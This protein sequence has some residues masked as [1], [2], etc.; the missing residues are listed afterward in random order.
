MNPL[1][2]LR[3]IGDL[4]IDWRIMMKMKE[5]TGLGIAIVVFLAN[6]A[7]LFTPFIPKEYQPIAAAG[8]ALL[9]AI[10]V[11]IGYRNNPDGTDIRVGYQGK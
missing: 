5:R 4:T 9:A 7:N 1:K 10:L 3:L 6:A 2:K 8:S 11:K